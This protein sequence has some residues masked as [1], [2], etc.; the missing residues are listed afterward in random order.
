M[1]E[2]G[3]D[4]GAVFVDPLTGSTISQSNGLFFDSE[5]QPFG[6]TDYGGGF[7]SFSDIGE[8]GYDSDIGLGF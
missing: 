5:G 3:G 8:Y 4:T 2:G 1:I 6:F 7:Q